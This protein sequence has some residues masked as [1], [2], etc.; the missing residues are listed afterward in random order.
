MREEPGLEGVGVPVHIHLE[1]GP[2]GQIRQV[3]RVKM[4]RMYRGLQGTAKTWRKLAQRMKRQWDL[5]EET[6]KRQATWMLRTWKDGGI[7][8]LAS[9]SLT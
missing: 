3:K 2:Y 6:L 8:M 7:F 4:R 1:S 9:A 5:A